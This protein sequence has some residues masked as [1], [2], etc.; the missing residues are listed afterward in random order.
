MTIIEL[1]INNRFCDVGRD[2]G[3]R[4]N[5]QLLNPGE[6]N[7][8]DAQYSYSITLPP[9]SNNHAIFNYANI[10]ETANKF[11]REYRAELIINSVRVFVGAFRLSEVTRDKY[12]GNLYIPA[13]KSIKDIFGGLKLNENPEY[14]ITIKDF[15]EYVSRYNKQAADG[16]Q[17]AIF[18]YTLYGVLPKVSQSRNDNTF[19]SRTV[20]DDSVRM[21]MQDLAPSINPLLMLKH[22]FNAQGYKLGGT[23]FDDERLARLYMSYKNAPDYVQPWNYG[24]LGM[25]R[26]TGE[27]SNITNRRTGEVQYEKG[28]TYTDDGDK[29]YACDLFDCNNVKVN[30]EKDPGGNVVYSEVKDTNEL[31]WARTQIMIPATGYYKIKLKTDTQ[32]LGLPVFYI[33]P[34]TGVSFVGAMG[35]KSGYGYVRSALKV[36]RDRKTGDFGATKIDGVLYKNNLRQNN[37]YDTANTPKYMPTYRGADAGSIIFVDLAQNDRHIA[38]FQCGKRNDDDVIPNPTGADT[39][40]NTAKITVAKPALSWDSSYTGGYSNR[41]GIDTPGYYKYA[42]PDA[43]GDAPEWNTTN[44]YACNISNTPGSSIRKGYLNGSSVDEKYCYEGE[45]NCIVWLEAGELITLTDVSDR[46]EMQL[47]L[48]FLG[49]V[50]KK[51]AFDLEITPFRTD[52]SWLKID[53]SGIQITGASMDWND[54][55]NFDVDSIN[56]MGFLPADM[57]T[58]DFIDNFCKAFNL[59]L[60][61]I[62]ATTFELNVK[63]SKTAVSNLYIDLDKFVSVRDRSNTPLGLPSLYKIGFTVDVEEEGYVTTEKDDGGGEFETGVT[64]EKVVE[65]KSVFSYNWFKSITK[66]EDTGNTVLPLAVISKHDVWEEKV[67][68]PDAI[69][70]R[71]TNQA[72]RFWYYDGLL[73]DLGASFT[74]NNKPLSI[75]KVSNELPGLSLLSYKNQKLTILDNFFTLLINGSSHYTEVEGY[76]TPNQYEDLNGSIMAMFNGDLYYVAEISGYDP[77]GRNKTKIKLIRKI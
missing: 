17:M 60:T 77:T 62:D 68:Y 43:G 33:D 9:T 6:L 10:E 52:E 18:P 42:L 25:I 5:R 1:Y 38:G 46:G 35:P 22:I 19:S 69:K 28:V 51:I 11:N 73:N 8:K 61:Q 20:W 13:A 34:V 36:L 59:R 23:V 54:P 47:G 16:P 21:G 67:A 26:V 15:A 50:A 76:L 71:Y 14:R 49:W 3:V 41:L 70:K 37:Q 30:I 24:Y 12:K 45:L 7:T 48:G 65:Q 57:K 56:L 32:L 53:E 64:E 75:A 2:F 74:F 29:L 63:Q 72:I 40:D 27:W 31:V 39:N 58:D 66:V 44:Q 4:L 55:V